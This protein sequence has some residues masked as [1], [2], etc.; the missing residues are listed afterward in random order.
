MDVSY[1]ESRVARDSSEQT[2][3]ASQRQ[4]EV[5]KAIVSAPCY[6]MSHLDMYVA[7]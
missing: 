7:S 5:D 6:E 2:R 4:Y 3:N 1:G